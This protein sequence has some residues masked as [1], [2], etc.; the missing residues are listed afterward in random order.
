VGEPKGSKDEVSFM[1]A[2]FTPS[3]WLA[4][5]GVMM[6]VAVVH[7][8][9]YV[10]LSVALH[11]QTRRSNGLLTSVWDLLELLLNQVRYTSKFPLHSG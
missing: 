5:V 6:V 1:L 4:F 8:L 3:L 10:A 7:W 11:T 2:P 9:C